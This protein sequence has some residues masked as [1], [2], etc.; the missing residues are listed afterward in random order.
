MIKHQHQFESWIL[1]LREIV[2]ESKNS[3]D[4]VDSWAQFNSSVSCIH[5]FFHQ[6][7][8]IKLLDFRIWSI[9][10]SRNSQR[11]LYFMIKSVVVFVVIYR[12]NNR[13]MIETKNIYLTGLLPIPTNSIAS[14]NKLEDSKNSFHINRLI[15]P[16]LYGPKGPNI[17]ERSRRAGRSFFSNRWLDLLHLDLNPTERSTRDQKFFKR[18][19]DVSFVLSRRCE[20]KEIINLFKIIMYLQNTVSIHPIS[21]DPGC[22][23]V[24]KNELLTFPNFESEERFQEMANLFNLSITKPDLM[25]P[26][27]FSID[28]SVLDPKLFFLFSLRSRARQSVNEVCN[29]RDESKKKSLL[30]LPPLFYEENESF[31]PRIIQKWAQTSCRNDF[32][33]PKPRIV[34][35][36]SNG[37][38]NQY[39]LIKNLIQ[40]QYNTYG[41]IRNLWNRFNRNLEYGIQRYQIQNDIVNHRPRRKYTI[42]QHFSN[43]KKSQKNCLT[44][45]S[46]NKDP[47]AYKY[48]WSNGS[49]NFQEY[50]DRFISEQNSRFQVVFDRLHMNAY[51]I[52]WSE[53]IHKKD[54]SKSL[55]FFFSKFLPFFF[56]SLGSIPVHRSEIHMY[57]LKHPN[58]PLG[59]QLLESLG[60][61]IVHW[62]KR[63][64]FLLDDYY[65]SP[66]S[67][68]L[69]NEGTISNTASYFSMISHDQDNWLNP[70]KPFHRSSLISSFYKV[71]RLRFLNNQYNFCF[72]W[73]RR[74]SFYVKRSWNLNFTYGQFL[75][76]LFIQKKIFSLC[77]G[78]KKHAFLDRDTISQVSK[79]L[80]ANDFLQSGDDGYKLDKSFHFPTRSD[81]FVR[82]AIY[83]IADISGTPLTEEK[84][85][86]FERTNCQPLSD[87]NLPDSEGKNLHQYLNF[88]SNMALIHTPY[89][90]KYLR[91]KKRKKH[92]SCLKK[93]LEK[94]QMDRKFQRKS[95]FSTLY[96]LKR[97]RRYIIPWF[98]TG[99]AHKYLNLIL[100][101]TFSDLL[102]ILR[103]SP[104]F[105][106][107]VSIFH[108]IIDRRGFERILRKKWSLSQR[109]PIS[110][111]SSKCLDNFLVEM[112]NIFFNANNES[113][114]ISTRLR[115][116][117]IWDSLF[118]ILFL[119]FVT[120]YLLSLV[121]EFNDLRKEFEQVKSFMI[122]SY[123]IELRKLLDRYPP[124]ELNSFG[125]KKIFLVALEQLRNFQEERRGSA[126]GSNMLRGGGPAYGVKDLISIIPN[127]INRIKFLKNTR[128]LSHTSK[129]IYSLIRKKKY[130]NSDWISEKMDSW[131]FQTDCI[132]DKEREFLFQ[133]YT[134]TPEKGID[135]ILLSLTNSYHLSKNNSG[136]QM[137]EQP[138]TIYLRYLIDIHKKDLMTYEL[139]SFCLAERRIFLA[140]CQTITYSENL[141]GASSLD[142]PSHGKPF[143][144]RLS[145]S[146]PRGIL[147]IGSIG[148]GR[149]YLVRHLSTNS[150][151]P[152][153]TIFLNEFLDKYPKGIEYD[154]DNEDDDL[155]DER[156]GTIYSL[157]P[158]FEDSCYDINKYRNE[159]LGCNFD[160]DRELDFI[161]TKHPLLEEATHEWEVDQFFINLQFDLVKTMSPCIIW[162]P[163]IHDLNRKDSNDL[164]LAL[165]LLVNS[166][167]EESEKSSTTNNL[168]IASTHSPKKVDPALISPNKLNT[169][170][171]IRRLLIPQQ[172][173]HFFTL[174]YT[175]GFHLEKKMFRTNAFGSITLGSN[176]RDLVALSNEALSISI[177]QK[178]SILDTNI[179]R[180]ALHRQTWDFRS[181][182]R[183]VQDH[184]ILFYQVGRALS[185][186]LL[187]SNCSIDPISIYMKKKSCNEGDSFLYRW[188][189]ELG[190]SM[191][192]LTI[193]L[194]LLSCSA[195]SVAQDLWS[196]PGPNEKNDGITSYRLLENDSDL[197]HGLLEVEG[198]L[199]G[200]SQTGSKFDNDGVTLLLRTER[201]NP[202]NMIRNGSRSVFD[203]DRRFLYEKY[204]SGFEEEGVLD[205]QPIEEDLFN[206]IVWAPRIWRP[207]GF[208]FDCLE[209][210]NE[211]GFWEGSF[212]DKEI[213]YDEDQEDEL[214]E[215]HSEF[216][217]EGTMQYE[218]RYRSSKEQDV[219]QISQFIW[220]PEDPL[221]LLF[222]DD[223]LVSAFLHREFFADEEISRILLT[224]QTKQIYW[225]YLN[226]RWF[227]KNTQEQE[228]N[229]KLLI[230]RQRWFRTNSSLS[231][232]FS[233]SNTL[234][235]SYQYLSNLLLSNG[236]LVA[237]IT[238]TLL[239]KRWLFPDEMVLSIS[240]NND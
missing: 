145:L 45:R 156:E 2:R 201:R 151:L 146:P 25:Y 165:G 229:F 105:Q 34:L 85:V 5:V 96:K 133:F 203:Q 22:D 237:Q 153:I 50:F 75:N 181:Q 102:A 183:S 55:Y 91:S 12:I 4:F 218:T 8:L 15:V 182:I 225:R 238:K 19:A 211:L 125:L 42:N 14:G 115:S 205:P 224:C 28:Y 171:K 106:K 59:N 116:L 164:S 143:S 167:S 200:S 117:T 94:G 149:S 37:A 95:P 43:L 74:F 16:L 217:Q 3:V 108:G 70:V 166:L 40:I 13:K 190:T 230:D 33:D 173:K 206:H 63:K 187:L 82:R 27:G 139:N 162:I 104:Q 219:F 197:V 71:T 227:R 221:F 56:V 216:L 98:L 144:L 191:K 157:L 214:Q 176:I 132:A 204:E 168:I 159:D 35:F 130:V 138:G 210:S 148:T 30:V 141:R 177:I 46:M 79:I 51:S 189:Y 193:L 158:S 101:E 147:V 73:N 179:I 6:E 142:S 222:Q 232:G 52:D 202:L 195:G 57:E 111:I 235:E 39:G 175:K 127:P 31:Y 161:S 212:R 61:Q 215:N 140:H 99:T 134:L 236:T 83:S 213:I 65:T 169:C 17:S 163:N 110:K 54:L 122:P 48:K 66:K 234:S 24:T 60:L 186:N 88:D 129:A 36:T 209:R 92:S 233:R 170:I 26:K 11:N 240:A 90:E 124:S 172:R 196:L 7:S 23:R 69:I 128:H 118:S 18:E 178:K 53:V 123:M 80:I 72:D 81:P 192:K 137:V 121:S 47:N 220:D 86:N 68:L 9:L 29:S 20:N 100:R 184:G 180:S 223:P 226:K 21:S 160:F 97:F 49:K 67:K 103:R 239:R 154:Y 136:Y 188:Y 113:A 198:A 93:S 78:K 10:F 107:F 126:S 38:V 58:D 152:F 114:L 135:Q 194:Y 62:K 41:Y 174:S 44:E 208:L 112:C 1:E 228:K 231:N 150:Y 155:F 199:V 77:D 109:N 76:I 32:Q 185:Q 64:P 84:I 89:S 119:L 131:I 207:W 87:M 120:R